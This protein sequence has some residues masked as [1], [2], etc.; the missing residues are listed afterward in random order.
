MRLRFMHCAALATV[1]SAQQPPYWNKG[2]EVPIHGVGPQAPDKVVCDSPEVR[3]LI[4]EEE[5]RQAEAESW[6]RNKTIDERR[7]HIHELLLHPGQMLPGHREFL[8]AMSKAPAV[9]VPGKA[10]GKVVQV[11]TARCWPDAFSGPTWI[12]F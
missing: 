8:D 4:A 7:A 1:L 10:R 2:A 12:N 5:K 6:F 11:S 9:P 3:R